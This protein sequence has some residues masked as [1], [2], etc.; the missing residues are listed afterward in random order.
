M[1]GPD[2]A[3]IRNSLLSNP[4]DVADLD[5]FVYLL[6][7]VLPPLSL[8]PT[9]EIVLASVGG[10]LRRLDEFRF[11][12]ARALALNDRS[13]AI[14]LAALEIARRRRVLWEIHSAAEH[15]V[16]LLNRYIRSLFAPGEV[17]GAVF[18]GNSRR[19]LGSLEVFRGKLC[20][21]AFDPKP[22]LREALALGA[23]GILLAHLDPTHD[24]VYEDETTS[25]VCERAYEACKALE[26]EL[27]D[28]RIMGTYFTSVAT[29]IIIN[30]R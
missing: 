17:L 18:L 8:V 24:S 21:S 7:K 15:D 25:L 10:D 14:L 3:E 1:M 6:R 9:A 4:F 23:V 13:T 26:I 29:P 19:Y 12:R 22:M 28:Y 16:V 30:R 20:E 5:L 27:V 2:L 11:E